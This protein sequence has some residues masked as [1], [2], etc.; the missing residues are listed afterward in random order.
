MDNLGL[1]FAIAGAVMSV[2]LAGLGSAK[3]VGMVG[4]AAAGVVR[5]DPSKFG[6]MIILQLLPG[7]QGLYGLIA[8]IIL[9]SQIGLLGGNPAS[10]T[11][12]QGLM[13]FIA[14]LPITIVGYFSALYQARAAIAGVNIVAKKP[15]HS[16]KALSIS[17]MVETYAILA[18][19]ISILAIIFIK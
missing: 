13:Y 11:L 12:A 3:G 1:I 5:E 18:L 15:D 6:K 4:E 10:L 9:F 2:F 14:C 19:L 17:A 16:G 8:A 7:T